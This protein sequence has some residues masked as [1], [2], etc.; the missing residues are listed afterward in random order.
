MGHTMMSSML[1]ELEMEEAA[2]RQMLE[3]VPEDKLEWRPHPKSMTLGQLALHVAGTIGDVSN[4][5]EVETFDVNEA[6]FQAAQPASSAEIMEKFSTAQAAARE[7][8]AALT[9]DQALTQWTL[10]KGD[11]E[12]FSMPK[13][14]LARMLMMNHLYHHRGQLSVYL[15][16]LD[17]PVP[18]TYGRT[19][20]EN[21]FG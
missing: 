9:D 12:I 3:R 13:V 16:L 18:V 2:T 6:D 15:R 11:T 4:F 14:A 20:D 10:T 8:F 19:A 7:R 1:G 21:P 5:L 17:V